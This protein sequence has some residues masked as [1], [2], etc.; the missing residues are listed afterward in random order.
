[1]TDAWVDRSRG[2]PAKCR[3]MLTISETQY[4]ALAEHALVDFRNRLAA[5]LRVHAPP[6]AE[7]EDSALRALIARQEVRAA[8]FGL[9]TR[10]ELAKWCFIAVLT[11]ERFDLHPAVIGYL[12]DEQHGGRP[13]ER[14]DALMGE[15]AAV[16]DAAARGEPSPL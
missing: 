16:A 2:L 1:M 11:A 8:R 14:L 3:A 13:G 15:Y 4:D 7:M 12:H 5:W 10:R 6:A 9:T